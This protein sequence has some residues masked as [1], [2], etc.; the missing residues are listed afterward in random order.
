MEGEGPEPEETG[1]PALPLRC[2][3]LLCENGVS[4][5]AGTTRNNTHRKYDMWTWKYL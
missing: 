1:K 4:K 2:S 3:G 5:Y